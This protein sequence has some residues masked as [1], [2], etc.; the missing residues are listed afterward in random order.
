MPE[1]RSD[2]SWLVV[3]ARRFGQW[4]D[5][6]WAKGAVI[7]LGAMREACAQQ[8]PEMEE[9]DVD[10]IIA[11]ADRDLSA[12]AQRRLPGSRPSAH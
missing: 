10:R 6:Q 1:S 2:P 12:T 7:T 8:W 3:A 4:R 5:A 11:R 9:K